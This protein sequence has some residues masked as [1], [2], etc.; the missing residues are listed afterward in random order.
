M[1]ADFTDGVRSHMDDG[2]NVYCPYILQIYKAFWRQ[3]SCSGKRFG[4]VVVVQLTSPSQA[5]L[6]T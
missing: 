6:L 3:T 2:D 5:Q 4:G 1:T